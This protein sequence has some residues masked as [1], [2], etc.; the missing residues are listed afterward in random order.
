MMHLQNELDIVKDSILDK[1]HQV[2]YR[3]GPVQNSVELLIALNEMEK[4]NTKY[5]YFNLIDYHSSIHKT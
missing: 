4:T 3:F 2:K 5:T 1:R